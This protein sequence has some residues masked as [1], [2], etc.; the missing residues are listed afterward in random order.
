MGVD[1]LLQPGRRLFPH[2]QLGGVPH[3]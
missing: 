2:D 1:C 3:Q